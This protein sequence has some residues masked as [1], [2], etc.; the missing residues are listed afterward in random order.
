MLIPCYA[1]LTKRI[2]HFLRAMGLMMVVKSPLLSH[3]R[4]DASANPVHHLTS[5]QCDDLR[6]LVPVRDP[7]AA[8]ETIGSQITFLAQ[9]I[10]DFLF[11]MHFI[12][13]VFVIE[14]FKS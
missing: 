2:M 12:K 11:W 7:F 14:P 5:T 4:V 8:I 9:S 13:P 6:L 1:V 3:V 10:I